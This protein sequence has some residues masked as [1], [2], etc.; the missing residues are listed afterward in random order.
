MGEDNSASQKPSGLRT[1]L[2]GQ[3]TGTIVRLAV[4]PIDTI[5]ARMQVMRSRTS[6]SDLRHRQTWMRL[7]L[8]LFREEGLRGLYRGVGITVVAGGPGAALYFTSF[9][10]FKSLLRKATG[11]EQSFFI[12][13]CSAILAEVVSC[14]VWVPIDV[15]KERMQVMTQLQ[16]YKYRNTF[17]AISQISKTEGVRGL[18]KAYGATVLAFGP[19]IG[20]SMASAPIFLTK[21]DST[22]TAVTKAKT[23]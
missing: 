17:D 21:A 20:I 4:H 10:R 18:Y 9:E 16:T 7:A 15:I 3:I 14:T 12:S 22:V 2:A 19:F 23:C 11:L 8:N 13:F 1:A 5:K 6:L